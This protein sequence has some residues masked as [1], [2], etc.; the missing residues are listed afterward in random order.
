MSINTIL[1]F[2]NHEDYLGFVLWSGFL[3]LEDVNKIITLSKKINMWINK[4][5]NIGNI[6]YSKTMPYYKW[7]NIPKKYKHFIT[8]IAFTCHTKH[9][10][11]S[12]VF[13]SLNVKEIFIEPGFNCEL[14]RL[15]GNIKN[16]TINNNSYNKPINFPYSLENFNYGHNNHPLYHQLPLKLKTLE[17]YDYNYSLN[18]LHLLSQLTT[19]II[20]TNVPIIK[21]PESLKIFIYYSTIQ[22]P[23]LPESIEILSFSSYNLPF[24]KLPSELI[25]LDTGYHYNQILPQLPNKLKRI[26]ISNNH[27][28]PLPELPESLEELFLGKIY[29]HQIKKFPKN[30]KKLILGQKYNHQLLSLPNGLKKLHLSFDYNYPIPPLPDSLEELDCSNYNIYV[31]PRLPNNLK[32]LNCGNNYNHPLPQLPNT[33]EYL[34]CGDK[35]NYPLPVLPLTLKYLVCGNNYNYPLPNINSLI[36]LNCGNN[37]SYPLPNVPKSQFR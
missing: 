17:L 36:Y 28:K 8:S 15:K 29:N 20:G 7:L 26:Y 27:D 10:V 6:L 13:D 11:V 1:S 32:R 34:N 31:L 3:S 35:Y 2:N 14:P 30:L 25:K 37:Y 24:N 5:Q 12:Y 23:D 9:Y 16:I 21:L 18:S 19:L 4:G 22:L 33:L